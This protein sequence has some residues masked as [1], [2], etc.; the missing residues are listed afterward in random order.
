MLD[1]FIQLIHEY[2]A[3]VVEAVQLFDKYKGLEQPQHPLDWQASGIPQ[4]GYLDPDDKIDYFLHGY[5][6]CVHLPSGRI[7]WDFGDKGQLDGFDL[8]RLHEFAEK[9]TDNFP[10]F[11]DEETLK[12]VFVEAKSKGLIYKSEYILYY[13]K[14]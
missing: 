2:Q 14:Q 10:E 8:W 7:D 6:C 11:R 4:S 13:L 12:S 3:R 9:G 1:R 5:G